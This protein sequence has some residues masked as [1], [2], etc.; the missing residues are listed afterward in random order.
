M[1][2]TKR[3]LQKIII[4]RIGGGRRYSEL[5]A[6]P[7][8]GLGKNIADVDFPIVVGYEGKSEIAYNQE[9]LDDILDMITGGP[10]SR[11]NIPYSLDSLADIEPESIPSGKRIE[12]Y[13][14]STMKITKRQLRKIIREM[15]GRQPLGTLA[16]QDWFNLSDEIDALVDKYLAMGYD[17]AA[18]TAVILQYVEGST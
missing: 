6:H 5:T 13:A 7:R 14:E 9:E 1:K 4:E 18:I 12:R 16:Q 10:G 8:G 17:K 15:D 2:I 11:A 3:Q